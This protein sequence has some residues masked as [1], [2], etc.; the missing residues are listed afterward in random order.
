MNKREL[1][2]EYF[3]SGYNCAQSVA[4][5]FK[6]ELGLEEKTIAMLSCGFGGG[7]GRQR[8][9]CGAVSAMAFVLGG[10]KGYF[11]PKEVQGKMDV[12][13]AIQ[14]VCNQ[15]KTQNGSIICAELL[16]EQNA[17]V[18]FVPEKRTNEYY[19]KRPCVN[20]CG[21]AAEILQNYLEKNK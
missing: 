14:E 20:L 16:G 5:A 10:L 15:F 3:R 8:L 1:A 21:D 13:K 6:D 18:T 7:L 9:V 4:L 11:D 12:Y 2:E 19:K 17:L